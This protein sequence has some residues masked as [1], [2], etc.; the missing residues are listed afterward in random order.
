MRLQAIEPTAQ[1]RHAAVMRQLQPRVPALLH[2]G[3]LHA[4][5]EACMMLPIGCDR[6][7]SERLLISNFLDVNAICT[8]TSFT[9][10]RVVHGIQHNV[11]HFHF[12]AAADKQAHACKPCSFTSSKP[13][14]AIEL[15][16]C[17]RG[18]SPRYR[19][20]HVFSSAQQR[21]DIKPVLTH[22]MEP[23]CLLGVLTAC[24]WLTYQQRC[25][26]S[27]LMCIRLRCWCAY[28]CV[29]ACNAALTS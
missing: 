20:W 22:N 9:V 4:Q 23:G 6:C 28:L 7:A 24:L 8:C 26:S 5:L 21:L 3:E 25:L 18:A 1:A 17:G 12:T 29:L 14:G 16:H 15:T 13:R 19:F 27:C 11:A 10:R 2:G